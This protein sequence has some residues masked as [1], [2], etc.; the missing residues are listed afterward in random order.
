[1]LKN[2]LNYVQI[3]LEVQFRNSILQL[4][5]SLVKKGRLLFAAAKK[6]VLFSYLTVPIDIFHHGLNDPESRLNSRSL[7]AAAYE[8]NIS[9]KKCVN[10]E[11]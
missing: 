3:Q 7:N 2:T 10:L 5:T 8:S 9:D 11:V 6:V 1:M 4:R